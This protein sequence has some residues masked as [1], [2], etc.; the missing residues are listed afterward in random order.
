MVG[1]V[2]C[3]HVE[4][5]DCPWGDD[6]YIYIN[7]KSRHSIN[8]Q[9]ICD[10]NYKITNVVARWPGS[11]HDSRILQRSNIGQSFAAGDLQGILIG[12]SGYP[13][14]PWLMTP[15]L[16]PATAPEEDYNR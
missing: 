13:L 15:I 6:E 4:I 11:A 12:D 2:D 9:L 10:A 7:R 16:H 1:A 14:R 8:V 3:T 5:H